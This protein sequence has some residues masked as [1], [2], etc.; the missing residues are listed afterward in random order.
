[1]KNVFRVALYW[2]LMFLF[3]GCGEVD[4]KQS[5]G[6]GKVA[7]FA[8]VGEA[9]FM[10]DSQ[11]FNRW[12][13]LEKSSN[14]VHLFAE[15]GD[16]L[17]SLE[18]S[19]HVVSG[20][21]L[22]HELASALPADTERLV[23]FFATHGAVNGNWCYKSTELCDVTEDVLLDA[24]KRYAKQTL[25]AL[26]H[27][28]IIP[29][30]CFNKVIM[31]R[32]AK[33]LDEHAWPFA[34]SYLVQVHDN[35]CGTQSV[36]DSL[37]NNLVVPLDVLTKSQLDQ[38]LA[39]STVGELVNFQNVLV[40]ST[41]KAHERDLHFELR[42]HG[43]LG[44]IKLEDFGFDLRLLQGLYSGHLSPPKTFP[45]GRSVQSVLQEYGLLEQ[46]Y[47]HIKGLISIFADY[48]KKVIDVDGDVA[49][50]INDPSMASKTINTLQ[51]IISSKKAR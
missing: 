33:K 23:I 34:I 12:N 50:I 30:S 10:L 25:L 43:E 27:V 42:H 48:S 31:D 44:D 51:A 47:P 2:L 35:K 36:S 21:K 16:L 13:H 40:T 37:L 9:A 22:A 26:K 19:K 11:D 29:T 38:F 46:Y 49:L 28:L 15:H 18:G 6:N 4:K 14:Q 41:V 8:V 32:F 45:Q 24:L 7:I 3:V 1:M 39:L 17:A 5:P 20:D